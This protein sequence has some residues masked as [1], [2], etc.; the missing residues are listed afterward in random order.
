[1]RVTI[2]SLVI[3]GVSTIPVCGQNGAIAGAVVDMNGARIPEATLLLKN[4]VN[5][6]S[7]NVTAND[8]GLFRFA[9]LSPGHYVLSAA[10]PGFQESVISLTLSVEERKSLTLVLA[11]E[12]VSE[13]VTVR[14]H[15]TSEHTADGSVSTIVPS[16]LV[17][18]LPV[19]GRSFQTLL[20]LTPGLVLTPTGTFDHGQF[21]VNGQRPNSNYMTVDGVS[22]NVG[23]RTAEYGN[24]ELSGSIIS[25]G[26]TG[27]SQGVVSIDEVQEFR[28]QTSSFAPEFGRTPGAQIQVSTRSG[29]NT[30]NG[31]L[32]EYIRNDALDATDWFVNSRRLAKPPLRQHDFGATLGGPIVRD[33]LFYFGSLESL[34]LVQPRT[35]G[36][37]VPTATLRSASG[38][39][40]TSALLNSF[41]LPNQPGTDASS[42]VFAS[43]YG[44]RMRADLFS[45]RGDWYPSSRLVTFLR[46]AR[47]PGYGYQGLA[48]NRTRYTS[49]N[50]TITAGATLTATPTLNVDLRL[51]Y[52]EASRGY[53]PAPEALNGAQIPDFREIIPGFDAT[54]QWA[55][56]NTPFGAASAGTRAANRQRQFNV[57]GNVDYFRSTHNIRFGGDIRLL[58]PIVMAGSS[59]SVVIRTTDDVMAAVAQSVTQA[60]APREVTVNY[61][62]YSLYAQDTQR[63]GSRVTLTYGARWEV[64]PPPSDSTG[65]PPA[66]VGKLG[67]PNSTHIVLSGR[68]PFKTHWSALAPRL[69]VSWN[70]LTAG[71]VQVVFRGGA[72]VFYDLSPSG[73]VGNSGSS[74]AYRTVSDVSLQQYSFPFPDMAVFPIDVFVADPGVRLPRTYQYNATVEASSGVRD[75]VGVSYVGAMGRRLVRN[76]SYT[77]LTNPIASYMAVFKTDGTSDYN[78]LQIQYRRS[79]SRFVQAVVSYAFAKSLDDASNEGAIPNEAL[80]NPR[81]ERGL[82]DFDI[83]QSITVGVVL[84]SPLQLRLPSRLASRVFE[85]WVVSPFVRIRS[86]TPLTVRAN[87]TFVGNT[88]AR[89]RANIVAGEPIWIEDSNV[90]RGRKLNYLAFQDPPSNQQG[91]LGRNAIQGFGLGQLDLSLS[92]VVAIKDRVSA[93]IGVEAFNVTNRANFGAPNTVLQSPLTFGIATSLFSGGLGGGPLNGGLNS[94]YQS[95]GSRSMQVSIRV[96]F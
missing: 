23:V 69:G 1:M 82:S 16:G 93:K 3:V 65:G 62:N 61:G 39:P 73:A 38:N 83:R 34:H 18:N 19:N 47:G 68:A 8:Q 15:V 22:G 28:V 95:G 13:Q 80:S 86:G 88:Y 85:G 76:H 43:S 91:T 30:L 59:I 53:A 41:P 21:S 50:Q 4:A 29:N 89:P 26:I 25:S 44:D 87:R 31:S 42:G 14:E 60:R 92:R 63:I 74:I 48:V 55:S 90:P 24:Q 64:N 12:T 67:D 81:N 58:R 46:Y 72:G 35:A 17:H 79:A 51:N 94:L 84:Q 33:Q 10:H 2:L 32:Y 37:L 36:Q 57:V 5:S 7:N 52:S 45:V 70:A 78:A 49:T 20:D 54:S 6:R 77:G 71:S 75:T 9:D 11:V 56:F 66:I 27:G 40:I 96:T